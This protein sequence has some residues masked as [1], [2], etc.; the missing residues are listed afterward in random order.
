M[1]YMERCGSSIEVSQMENTIKLNFQGLCP[2]CP[3]LYLELFPFVRELILEKV[4]RVEEVVL[5]EI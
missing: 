5:E 4:E 3:F 2:S 1:P